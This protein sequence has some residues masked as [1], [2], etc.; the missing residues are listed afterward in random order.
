MCALHVSPV[1]VTQ[2]GEWCVRFRDLMCVL[3]V[4]P[5]SFSWSAC[6]TCVS[7]LT[8][9]CRLCH[10]PHV[11]CTA[12]VSHLMCVYRLCHSPHVR[13][14]PVSFTSCACHP[15][16]SPE[17][18]SPCVACVIH[19]MCRVSSSVGC[20]TTGLGSTFTCS[21]PFWCWWC[22]DWRSTSISTSPEPE[23]VTAT[24]EASTTRSDIT[25]IGCNYVYRHEY[26]HADIDIHCLDMHLPAIQRCLPSPVQGGV[27]ATPPWGFS[28]IAK[29]RRRVAPP[30]FRLPYGANLTQ[31][32]AK[33]IW[34]G[35]VRSRSYDVIRGTTSGNF[36]NKV[37]F[38]RNLTWRHWCKC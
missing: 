19:L 28:R 20:G 34:P 24:S 37:V 7:H 18:V 31:F 2:C 15:C 38:S 30:G 12:C 22:C 8:Y 27:G 32:W 29:K 14:S 23:V 1:S 26:E 17:C 33:Q 3:R 13:V 11:P 21:R 9:V 25:R 5:V 35:Q 36:S 10:S 4:S 16:Q 6:V